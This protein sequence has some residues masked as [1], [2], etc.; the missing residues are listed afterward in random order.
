MRGVISAAAGNAPQRIQAIDTLRGIAVLG[1]LLLNIVSFSLPRAYID[2]SVY[3]GYQ[4]WNL[5]A[6][7]MT[8]L[9]FEG[10]MRGLFSLLFGASVLLLTGDWR[11]STAPQNMADLYY[12]RMVW[13][14]LFGIIHA[15]LLLWFGDVLYWYALA[16]MFLYPARKMRARWL[17]VI[18]VLLLATLIPRS[19][20]KVVD[21]STTEREAQAA[22]LRLS[23]GHELSQKE[24]GALEHWADIQRWRKP[25]RIEVQRQID[26]L[27]GDYL[28]VFAELKPTIIAYQS[29]ILYR[30]GFFDA[31]GMML[32]GMALLKAG[33]LTGERSQR[34][35][36]RLAAGGIGL[37]LSINVLELAAL[38]RH[39]FSIVAVLKWG[40][41]GLYYDLG[42][43]PL[44]LG[45]VGLALWVYQQGWLQKTQ[46]YL[47]SCGK[48][49]LTLYVS[50]SI[51]CAFIFYGFGLGWYGQLS[52]VEV[53]SVV[54][55]IWA[56]QL[57]GSQW[58]LRYYRFGPLEWLWRSLVY[59]QRQPMRR[60][61][62]SAPGA[63]S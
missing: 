9:F 10:T 34:F 53:Y 3:G 56:L 28:S 4:G 49:A 16:G 20:I 48:M 59:W 43:V 6:F 50:Q 44:T 22:E 45:Y 19:I 2:P 23:S 5:T 33:V 46:G 42:R 13:L 57:I 24:Q 35:Y 55:L 58:W 17:M 41:L 7:G 29:T 39:E 30:G 27:R 47:A 51:I 18:G 40:F 8:H 60:R 52:R 11:R 31:L 26:A 36:A 38:I 62:V 12:R 63:T 54:L 25:D 37:G 61:L 21:A 1:I 14:F 32:L 15:W